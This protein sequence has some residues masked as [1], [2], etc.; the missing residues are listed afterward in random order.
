[1]YISSRMVAEDES[2]FPSL[3]Q[4]QLNDPP[5]G[6]WL[7]LQLQVISIEHSYTTKW[8]RVIL[9]CDKT[10][11]A[12]QIPQLTYIWLHHL[13]EQVTSCIQVVKYF[14]RSSVGLKPNILPSLFHTTSRTK[15]FIQFPS[16]LLAFMGTT[17]CSR[18]PIEF[19]NLVFWMPVEI[20]QVA[21][22]QHHQVNN[23][24]TTIVCNLDREIKIM[25]PPIRSRKQNFCL[26][27]LILLHKL[28]RHLK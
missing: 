8:F 21:I 17:L 4:S 13:V 23:L 1:M 27:E 15:S 11:W 5:D 3:M 7:H 26:P 6:F 12:S 22:F 18:W 16:I 10:S 2:L 9:K 20:T 25:L 24:L 14:S 28:F 19:K